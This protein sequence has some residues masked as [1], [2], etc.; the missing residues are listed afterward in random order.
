MGRYLNHVSQEIK[1]NIVKDY[2][3][4]I[5]IRELE[6]RYNISRPSI[7][8][9]LTEVGVKTTEG[10]HYRQYFHNE[11]FFETIDSEEKAYWLGFMYA[12]G[13]IVSNQGRYGQEKV[14]ITLS[15][16]DIDHLKKFKKSIKATNPI[17]DVSRATYSLSRILLTSQ[18]TVN[19]LI[20]QGCVRQKSLILEFPTIKQ[21]PY[22]LLH[23]FVRGY[24]DGDGSISSSFSKT[25]EHISY[26]VSIVGT[27][28]FMY[29]CYLF[30]G[31]MGSLF[32]DKRKNNS[33]Y[34]NIGGNLQIIT[35]FKFLY[36]DATIYMDRKYNKFQELISKYTER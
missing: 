24:F 28:N 32:P 18:K 36:K 33:W 13:Y 21:V 22:E 2:Q 15:T 8:N 34:L 3:N 12:D 14:G 9:F 16:K 4:N 30:L 11:D 1:D 6:R 26:N 7:S 5:S 10:N 35:L 20:K 19:D 31:E 23:H 29:E 25:T 17:T 27:E